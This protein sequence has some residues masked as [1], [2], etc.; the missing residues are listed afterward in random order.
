MPPKYNEPIP[1]KTS[2]PKLDMD[3]IPPCRSPRS[4]ERLEGRAREHRDIGKGM[5]YMPNGEKS[6]DWPNPFAGSGLLPYATDASGNE[7]PFPWRW[8]CTSGEDARNTETKYGILYKS[9]K[10][11]GGPRLLVIDGGCVSDSG[12]TNGHIDSD[13]IC[14]GSYGCRVLVGNAG[15][16][17]QALEEDRDIQDLYY[18]EDEEE[19]DNSGVLGTDWDWE[20]PRLSSE[21][22]WAGWR[23]DPL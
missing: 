20:E 13:D 7:A 6:G 14:E 9:G 3:L 15:I 18:S 23:S 8:Y 19:A 11:L 10:P 22:L 12:E 17:V 2:I 5:A 16:H 1:Q 4:T 21:S